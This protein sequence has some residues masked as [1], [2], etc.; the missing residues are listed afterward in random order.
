ME[1]F[2]LINQQLL[3]LLIVETI[4]ISIIVG[5]LLIKLLIDLSNLSKA[6]QSVVSIIKIELEPTL[7]EFRKTLL[8]IN[9]IASAA[10]SQ[11][12]NLNRG[13]DVISGSTGKVF[14]K[15]KII[16]ASIRKGILTGFKVFM[17]Q[18]K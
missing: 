17:E 11:V 10:D 15:A 3:G 8:N 1:N 7:K 2:T 4:V 9:S 13:I 5:V 14:N 6:V 12:L 16:G 18:K